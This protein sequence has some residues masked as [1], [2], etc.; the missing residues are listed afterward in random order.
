MANPSP[1]TR[2]GRGRIYGS[3]TETIGDTPLVR[4]NRL[5]QMQGIKAQILAKL[6]FFNPIIERQ[7]PHRRL[8]DRGDGGRRPGRPRHRPDRADLRQY[9]HCARLRRGGARLPAHPGDAG[10]DVGG[11]PQDAGA[12]RRRTGAHAGCGRHDRR[13]HARRGAGARDQERGHPAAVQE[14]GQSGHPPP[15][16]RGGNLERHRRRRRRL[17]R[18]HRH[19]RHHHRGRPGAQEAQ[20]RG[21]RSSRSSPRTARCSRRAAPARTRSRASAPISFRK[22]STVR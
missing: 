4:L 6:E 9:R 2:P 18:G 16:H 17:R 21:A 15:H 10:F 19:R 7:G 12:A 8:D 11:A 5:P 1:S 20:A 3:I 13:R 22:S 14:P